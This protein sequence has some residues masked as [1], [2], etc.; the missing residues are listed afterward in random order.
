MLGYWLLPIRGQV[1]VLTDPAQHYQGAWPQIW[2]EPP[3]A[4]PGEPVTLYMRDN[5]PLP[6][7]KL[8]LNGDEVPRDADYPAGSGPWTWRWHFLAPERAT[9]AAVVYHSC[10]SGCLERARLTLG[11]PSPWITATPG[12]RPT[13][14]GV[15]FPDPRRDWHGRAGWGVELTYTELADDPDWG[16]DGLSR[17][18]TRAQ[19]QGLQVL[20]RIAYNKSQSLPPAG[21]ELALARYLAAVAR[22]ATDDRLAGVYGYFIGSG[23]NTDGENT[24]AP[25]QPTTPEWYARVFNGYGLAPSRSD[26]VVQTIRSIRPSIRVLV[27]PVTPWKTDQS[28]SRADPTNLPWLNYMNTLVA[29]L[30]E[31]TSAK[32]A[33]GMGQAAPDGFAL[34]APGRPEA[35]EVAAHPAREPATDLH[36]QGWGQ[37]QAGFRV[38][39]DWLT[40]INRYPTTRGRPAYITSTN[41][42]TWDTGVPPTQNYPAGW[43]TAAYEEISREPQVQALCWFVDNPFG[44]MWSEFSLTAHPGKINDAADEFDQLLQR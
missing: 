2:V 1:L 30:D 38:Y 12:P 13:I 34:Q 41:T 23:F 8:V 14:L 7:P 39:R 16:V 9:S 25:E 28:G 36:R 22:L 21:D 29:Y 42:F 31:A 15:V 24:L 18:V 5:A 43:L 40:I 20:V 19:Q 33:H 4:R 3:A 35:P 27:G 32:Q 17:R 11:P 44:E 37:A 10:H 26:N 6:F